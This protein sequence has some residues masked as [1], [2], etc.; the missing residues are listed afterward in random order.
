MNGFVSNRVF[1]K[2]GT[3]F[4]NEDRSVLIMARW[5]IRDRVGLE[6]TFFDEEDEKVGWGARV[7][8]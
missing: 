6:N 1:I 7:E 4:V 8:V 3:G 2:E 5:K